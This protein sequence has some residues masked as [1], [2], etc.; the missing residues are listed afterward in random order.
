[1][2]DAIGSQSSVDQSSLRQL[3]EQPPAVAPTQEQPPAVS[4]E[5]VC[6]APA[7]ES[8]FTD[9]YES[10]T[11]LGEVGATSRSTGGDVGG[12]GSPDYAPSD[13]SLDHNRQVCDPQLSQRPAFEPGG[14]WDGGQ[15]LNRLSQLDTIR[16]PRGPQYD[17]T[18]CG[19][20][21]TLSSAIMAGPEATANVADRLASHTTNAAN[22]RDI[23]G[24]RDRVRDGS[25][26]TGDLSRL[27]DHM[28]RQYAANPRDG[29]TTAEV[30]RMQ[31]ELMPNVQLDP[32]GETRTADGVRATPRPGHTVEEPGRTVDRVTNLRPG[33]SFS[34]FVDTDR[35]GRP[36]FNDPNHYVQVGRDQNG[37]LYVY[38]P[39]PRGNQP[40][41]VYQNRDPAAFEHY[42]T[43]GMG[44][45]PNVPGISRVNIVAGGT[46]SH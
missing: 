31:Q 40:N 4:E 43:G 10:S 46:V 23:E 12:P 26:S 15:I 45:N 42:T 21:S 35:P 13:P 37:E 28:L 2:V 20:S 3:Q 39:Y 27:Q 29:M 24:I 41:L 30:T 17:E 22:R 33:E 5:P 8:A 36:G 44:V 6:E 7:T 32:N 19:P 9:S 16:G 25:A 11:N 18:R 14:Q 38:D 34:M 1:M